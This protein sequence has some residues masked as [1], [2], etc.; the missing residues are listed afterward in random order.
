MRIRSK[1]PL[2]EGWSFDP[3]R[4]SEAVEAVIGDP[5][6]PSVRTLQPLLEMGVSAAARLKGGGS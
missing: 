3:G 6:R 2:V 1:Q 4:S 5:G